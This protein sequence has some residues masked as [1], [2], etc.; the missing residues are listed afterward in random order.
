[1]IDWRGAVIAGIG[2][3]GAAVFFSARTGD[4]L[5]DVPKVFMRRPLVFIGATVAFVITYV[6]LK[7]VLA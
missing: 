7:A 6:L 5:Q 4:R 3:L 1:M 2:F